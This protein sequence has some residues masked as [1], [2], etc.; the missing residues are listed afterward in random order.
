VLLHLQHRRLRQA[1]NQ[2]DAGSKLCLLYKTAL[3]HIPED[4]TPHIKSS[5]NHNTIQQNPYLMN[6]WVNSKVFHYVGIMQKIDQ[7]TVH[8][9]VT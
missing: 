1:S 8:F 6:L 5:P 4:S 2:Q 7:E 3:H 9:L